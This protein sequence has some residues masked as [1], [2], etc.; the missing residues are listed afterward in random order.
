[1]VVIVYCELKS[2]VAAVRVTFTVPEPLS[3]PA[4]LMISAAEGVNVPFTASVPAV[5]KLPEPAVVPLIVAL[6]KVSVPLL[7]M[8]EPEF[9]V[10][11][12]PLGAKVTPLFTVSAPPTLKL[13]LYCVCAVGV[14][15]IVS[16]LKAREVPLFEIVDPAADM[17][18]VPPPGANVAV[19][20]FVN[21][22]ATL[23]LLE[24]VTVAPDA[25][26]KL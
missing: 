13:V 8:D 15:A 12:P 24:V 19:E 6:L 7:L 2:A 9:S 10:I 4:P 22:P 26:V 1:M 20:L 3:V 23:K 21:V 16:P 14:V 11:V 5:A 25:M 18:M 17:V